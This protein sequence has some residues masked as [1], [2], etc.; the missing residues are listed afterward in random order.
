MSKVDDYRQLVFER[1]ACHL[2]Q[3]LTNPADV[4][5]GR[6]DSNHVGPWSLWQG[7]LEASLMVVGQDWETS[8][9]FVRHKGREGPGHPSNIVLMKL[10]SLAGVQ[11]GDPGSADGRDVAFFTNAILCLKGPEGG[12]QGKVYPSWFNNCTP[13][14][15]RQIEIVNPAV[16]VGL[17]E[18]AYRAIFRGF[19]MKCGYNVG[20]KTWFRV[21]VEAPTGRI[22]PNG[23]R[24][25]AVYH[26][27]R[28]ILNSKKLRPIEFQE[29]DWMRLR[30]FLPTG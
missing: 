26:C 27:A 24:A 16:V 10:V 13:F 30:P 29:N 7:N 23:S 25:F 5:R 20:G 2:C 21:E 4:E 9:Y 17:G 6:Y 22:L 1:K 18:H 15:R 19:G 3:G 14:L 12:S 28:R 11:L 8:D